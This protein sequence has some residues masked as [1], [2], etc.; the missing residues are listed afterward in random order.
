MFAVDC[1]L[2]LGAGTGGGET[3]DAV[4]LQTTPCDESSPLL[5]PIFAAVRASLAASMDVV[6]DAASQHAVRA[7]VWEWTDDEEL[8]LP[9]QQLQGRGLAAGLFFLP[10]PAVAEGGELEASRSQSCGAG[11]RL[12][13]PDWRT[14]AGDLVSHLQLRDRHQRY[15]ADGQMD[16]GGFAAPAGTIIVHPSNARRVI[17]GRFY[18]R[19]YGNDPACVDDQTARHRRLM[20]LAFQIDVSLRV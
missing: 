8:P 18:G 14:A 6:G 15:K 20:A 11:R 4:A 13:F 19:I 5:A 17:Y 1:C 3:C 16:V 10:P 2:Q 9:E 12:L 7:A